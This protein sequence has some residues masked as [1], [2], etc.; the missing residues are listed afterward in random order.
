MRRSDATAT[1]RTEIHCATSKLPLSFLRAIHHLNSHVISSIIAVIHF[2]VFSRSSSISKSSHVIASR[3]AS[4]GSKRDVTW[5]YSRSSRHNLLV[6][7]L[8][9]NGNGSH[10][11]RAREPCPSK[12]S[13]VHSPLSFKHHAS[14]RAKRWNGPRA[15]TR[16]EMVHCC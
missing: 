3:S 6:V 2:L 1:R 10:K 16:T 4:A 11:S 15:P 13:G 5:H 7:C 14:P 8:Q 12:E 9:E